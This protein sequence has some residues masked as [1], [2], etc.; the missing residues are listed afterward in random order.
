MKWL[1]VITFNVFL[2][3][4]KSLLPINNMLRSGQLDRVSIPVTYIYLR[5]REPFQNCIHKLL[6][7]FVRPYEFSLKVGTKDQFA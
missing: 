3:D 2:Y 5:K 1:V 7:V 4:C 6:L